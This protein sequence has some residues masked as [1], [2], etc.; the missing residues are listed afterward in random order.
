MS[1][2]IE[3]MKR[4]REAERL[5]TNKEAIEYSKKLVPLLFVDN[6]NYAF[7]LSVGNEIDDRIISV[8][9]YDKSNSR[10]STVTVYGFDS[11][12]M[13]EQKMKLIKDM[14]NGKI[15]LKDFSDMKFY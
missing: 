13:K 2:T 10:N 7:N 3:K 5:L 9:A 8:T 6:S 15:E 11:E 12:K 1:A 4:Q 14:F